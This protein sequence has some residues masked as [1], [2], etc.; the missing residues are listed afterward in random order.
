MEGIEKHLE[1]VAV[2]CRISS[3]VDAAQI[4]GVLAVCGEQQRLLKLAFIGTCFRVYLMIVGTSATCASTL[5]VENGML[6]N[7]IEILTRHQLDMFKK[8]GNVLA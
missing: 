7:K 1:S 6:A 5:Y 4:A 3:R 8:Y 2:M